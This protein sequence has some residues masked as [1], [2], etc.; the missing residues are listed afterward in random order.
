MLHLGAALPF[1]RIPASL[2]DNPATIRWLRAQVQLV[3][4]VIKKN[5]AS[6]GGHRMSKAG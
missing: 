5:V 1:V 2:T 6:A 3:T 4:R